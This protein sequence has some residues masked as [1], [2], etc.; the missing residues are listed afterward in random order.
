MY[1]WYV[2]HNEFESC[3]LGGGIGPHIYSVLWKVGVTPSNTGSGKTEQK[4]S[5]SRET[6]GC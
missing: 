2:A 1:T 3:L 6:R 4:S 5:L